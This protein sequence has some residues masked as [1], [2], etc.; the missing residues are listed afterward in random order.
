MAPEEGTSIERTGASALSGAMAVRL[1][2]VV[3]GLFLVAGLALFT[4]A[5]AR[6]VWPELLDGNGMLAYGRVF[7]AG[8]DALLFGWLTVA[9]LGFAFYA[10]PRL[11]GVPLAFPLAAL[12]VL[13]LVAGGAG[14]GVA[15]VLLGEN[16]GGRWLEFPLL[17]DAA[18]AAGYAGAAG[19]LVLTARRGERN[20]LPLPT[21]YLVAGSVWLFL[22]EF[23]GAIP[24]LDGLPAEIQSAF[25]GTALFGLWAACAGLGVAYSV[26]GGVLTAAGFNE[27]LGRI[28]FWSLALTWAWTAGRLLQHGPT[29]DWIE[30]VPVV[31]GAGLVVA[32]LAIAADFAGA[33]QGR[34]SAVKAS[35]PLQ[36]V[37][38]GLG[39][40]VL[41]VAAAFVASLRS[42]SAVVQFT[43]WES[44]VETATL[45]GAFTFF[46][47]AGITHV[48]PAVRGKAWGRWSGRLVVWPMVAGVGLAVVTRLFAGLQQGL[49]WL[50]GVQSGAYENANEGFEYSLAPLHG[51]DL[52]QMIGLGLVLAGA[53]VFMLR[54]L[55]LSIG[56]AA[57]G[58]DA[59]PG[60]AT[61]PLGTLLRGAVALFCFAVVGTFVFPAVDSVA[62]AT[63]IAEST[64]N[65]AANPSAELGREVYVREGCWY[66]HTQQ[67]RQV[68][69][70]VGLGPVSQPGDYVYDPVGLAGSRRIGP[71]LTHQ[72][73]R[74]NTGSAAWVRTHLADPRADEEWSV[75]PS[76][77]YL[78]E[79][80]LTALSVYVSGLE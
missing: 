79:E 52:V 15:M 6:L 80:E 51:L 1:A 63:V 47:L 77:R 65:F 71:D 56:S 20:R 11:V 74:E 41:A 69:T 70:D 29:K 28:G 67:V 21:W 57:A 54:L 8:T 37:V 34:W 10:V 32:A 61:Q 16:T 75:M 58:E 24:G 60:Y 26:V 42:V 35:P 5:A 55:W 62:E 2:F 68:I 4:L 50:A 25:T 22:A 14:G 53:A 43:P 48:A 40:L 19:L 36:M 45:L 46:A 3:A 13:A 72:G 39:F 78:S 30:T 38:A 73:S 59:A 64:R 33:L 18:L 12:G 66:C 27:R 76:F 17:F 31:F 44:G 49:S 7:P 23:A 9:F